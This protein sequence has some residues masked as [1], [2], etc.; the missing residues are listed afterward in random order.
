MDVRGRALALA[1]VLVLVTSCT[2]TDGEPRADPL[3]VLQARPSYEQAMT[4][5][6]QMNREIRDAVTAVAP[7]VRWRVVGTRLDSGC[8]E[9][10]S[11]LG[12]E[13]T[14]LELWGAEGGV[15]DDRWS[16]VQA[17]ARTVATGY[18]LTELAVI[19]DRQDDHAVRLVNP[20]DGTVA[21]MSTQVNTSLLT[22]LGC[23]LPEGG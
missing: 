19:K 14:L 21:S 18:G 5:Y 2:T 6:T 10:F 22:T 23:F 12:G 4:T 3:G 13:R 11:N 8:G 1:L 15:P 9:P 20:D 16:A 17:A 7:S